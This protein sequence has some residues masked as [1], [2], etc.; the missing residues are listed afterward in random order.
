MIPA[1]YILWVDS[2]AGLAVGLGMFALA[3][4]LRGIY[5]MPLGVAKIL[6]SQALPFIKTQREFCH[7]LNNRLSTAKDVQVLLRSCKSSI[8]VYSFAKV[9]P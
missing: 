1:R 3:S 8:E 5:G 6:K 2:L 9:L 7:F 4:L